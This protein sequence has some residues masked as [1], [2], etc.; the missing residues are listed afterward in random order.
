MRE[1][2]LTRFDE[3]FRNIAGAN[4]SNLGEIRKETLTYEAE[5]YPTSEPGGLVSKSVL[6]EKLDRILTATNNASRERYLS[7]NDHEAILARLIM[8]I[9][10]VTE[11]EDEG[12]PACSDESE[13]EVFHKSDSFFEILTSAR[14]TELEKVLSGFDFYENNPYR[15]MAERRLEKLRRRRERNER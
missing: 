14:E 13:G 6:Q 3:A 2:I 10:S 15:E 8:Q 9:Y 1:S 5:Y 4:L 12:C 7:N 11:D